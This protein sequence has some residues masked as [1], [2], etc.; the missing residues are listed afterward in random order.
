MRSS[1]TAVALSAAASLAVAAAFAAGC[2]D[3][4]RAAAPDAVARTGTPVP[5][6]TAG[7]PESPQRPG[8]PKPPPRTVEESQ[9]VVEEIRSQ[10]DEKARKLVAAFREAVFDPALHGGLL[11]A[12]GTAKIEIDGAEGSWEFAFDGARSADRQVE[13]KPVS[14]AVALHQGAEAQLRRFA[15]LATRG[16]YSQVLGAAPPTRWQVVRSDDGRDIVVRPPAGSD[17]GRSYR[18]D[19]R[20]LVEI[21]GTADGDAVQR[22][23]YRW[24]EWESRHLLAEANED[25]NKA[26]Q[27]FEYETRDGLPL[28]SR[29]ILADG[30]HRCIATFSWTKVD[31]RR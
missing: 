8:P 19:A 23:V 28:L 31:R 26:V 18:L 5:P 1:R 21:A 11:A 7:T 6:P 13:M 30:M 3:R 4:T 17:P 29:A 27:T 14:V 22:T 25:A 15:I 12:A 2:E 16:P 24:A 9:R 20:G 10:H